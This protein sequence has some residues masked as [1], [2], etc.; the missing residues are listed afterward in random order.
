M[1]KLIN[2]FADYIVSNTNGKENLLF[3]TDLLA[4]QIAKS[5]EQS[6][7]LADEV[8]MNKNLSLLDFSACEKHL[9]EIG[10]VAKNEVLRYSKIDWNSI[11]KTNN[12]ANKNSTT[13]N[14]VS[15]SLYSSSGKK[16]NMMLCSKT[17]TD[18]K[19]HLDNLNVSGHNITEYNYHDKNS[20]IFNDRCIPMKKNQTDAIINDRRKNFDNLNVTCSGKCNYKKINITTRYLTCSCN[21][22]ES[23]VEVSPE[24]GKIFLDLLN[25]TNILI[26]RCY[27]TTFQFVSFFLIFSLTSS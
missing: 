2:Q 18:V 8:A 14:S 7:K 26:V 15:Y 22:S 20:P 5:D 1:K 3:E 16:I 6:K 25:N 27:K 17:L 19:I 13:A 23:S 11:L 24:M 21:S 9:K 12:L 4:I 10:E